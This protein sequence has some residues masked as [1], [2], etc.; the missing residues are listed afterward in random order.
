MYRCQTESLFRITASTA[1]KYM[2]V[3]YPKIWVGRMH[4]LPT[5]C[6]SWVGATHPAPYVP[7]PLWLSTVGK[8]VTTSTMINSSA[9][10]MR[11]MLPLSLMELAWELNNDPDIQLITK[12]QSNLFNFTRSSTFFSAVTI[13]VFLVKKSF[14][15]RSRLGSCTNNR[16]VT[17]ISISYWLVSYWLLNHNAVTV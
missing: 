8:Q 17:S 3:P 13:C 11:C 7:A 12:Y 9:A 15:I 2:Y 5:Q 1:C 6:Q 10:I 4:W 16:T 14:S